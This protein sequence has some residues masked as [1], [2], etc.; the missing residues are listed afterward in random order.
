MRPWLEAMWAIFRRDISLFLSYRTQLI[1]Q[2]LS[3]LFT[4]T[5]FYYISHLL[6]PAKRFDSPGGYFGFVMS[7][8]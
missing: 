6:H 3:P 4:I 7:A 2:I 1:T 8:W 5:I